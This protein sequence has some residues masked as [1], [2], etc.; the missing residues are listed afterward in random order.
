[1]PE[2][3]FMLD[4]SA[5]RDLLLERVS[6][7]A[8]ARV[9]LVSGPRQVG[10][11][12]LLLEIAEKL[13]DMCMYSAVDS[14][15]AALPGFWERVWIEAEQVARSRG[16]AVVLLDEVHLLSGW[17][18]RLKGEWDRLKRKRLPIHIVST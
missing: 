13:G 7:P 3:A 12:T 5:C 4:Y 2:S 1:M 15:E 14:P 6:E 11:T 10:K 8:P 16:K 17:S 18:S 9:Q